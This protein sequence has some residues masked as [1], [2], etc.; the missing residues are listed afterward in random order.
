MF[1]TAIEPLTAE[2]LTTIV[3]NNFSSHLK[4]KLVSNWDN[5]I[6]EFRNNQSLSIESVSKIIGKPPVIPDSPDMDTMLEA[7]EQRA[8]Y[9]N[10]CF[11]LDSIIG[12]FA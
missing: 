9:G 11:I 2:E 5:L 3:E 1:L 10:M 7:Y 8:E 12:V 6:D 4:E